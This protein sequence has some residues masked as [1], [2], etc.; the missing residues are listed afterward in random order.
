MN[1]LHPRKPYGGKWTPLSAPIDPLDTVLI[2]RAQSI[3]S[4]PEL[5]T[6]P[7]LTVE[8]AKDVIAWHRPQH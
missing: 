7:P 6:C 8:Q 2:S 3:L 1:A 5:G 4:G